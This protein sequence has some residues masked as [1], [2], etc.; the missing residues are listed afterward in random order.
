MAL[1]ALLATVG[2][3]AVV[4]PS[5]ARAAG[6]ARVHEGPRK[7]TF[8]NHLH[9]TIWVAATPGQAPATLTRTGWVLPAGKEI[10][11]T[12]PNQWN[13]RF[14]G[15]TGCHFNAAG[16]GTCQTGDCDHLFQCQ[17]SGNI[18]ATLAEYNLD[19]WD[20]LDFYDVSMVDGSN[21]PMYINQSGGPTKDPI[22]PN[23]CVPAGCTKAVDC[24]RVLQDRAG[25][26]VLGCRSAC[27]R[28]NTDQYCCRGKW[29]SRAACN[30]KKWPVDY[31]AVFKRAEPYA[32]SYPYDDATST[33]TCYGDCNYR[34]TFGLTP[35]EKKGAG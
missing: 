15:R 20:H 28:F 3:V 11:I 26:V 23:G 31:A 27:S 33:F 22:S 2:V 9:E 34:I 8:V 4:Q 25:G 18:P 10:T 12:V 16:K 17:G 7:V 14:W 5:P 32:Y 6:A 30:P 24:P 13:G 29:S 1:V 35:V 19:A 21:V